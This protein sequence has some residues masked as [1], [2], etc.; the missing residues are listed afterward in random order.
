MKTQAVVSSETF[1]LR[2]D[3]TDLPTEDAYEL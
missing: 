1:I 2:A 3:I